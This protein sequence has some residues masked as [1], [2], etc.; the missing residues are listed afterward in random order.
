MSADSAENRNLPLRGFARLTP[1]RLA[2]ISAKG[3]KAAHE[4]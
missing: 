4:A 3:G 2:E 1:E